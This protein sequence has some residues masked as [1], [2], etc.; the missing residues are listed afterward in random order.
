MS[1]SQRL[2]FPDSELRGRTARG[3]LLNAFFLGG[4]ESLVLIQG[5]VVIALL[6]PRTIG[7]Y[8]I[9]STTAVTIIQLRRVGIDEAFVQQQAPDQAAEFQRAFTIELAIAAVGSVVIAA[10]API[11]AAIYHD[12]RLLWLTLAVSYLPIGFALQAPQWIF[13]RSMDFLR[14]RVLQILIPVLTFVVTVPLVI[15]GFGVW[16]LVIGPA[17]G[18]LAAVV[19]G[20]AISPYRLGLRPDRAAWRYYLRF[21]WPVFV[22][23]ATLLALQQG[24]ITAFGLR[25][26]LAAAGYITLAATL[27]RYV[28][29]ADLILTTTIYPAICAVRDRLD[30]LAE[31]FVK[32]SRLTL[33]WAF[34]FGASF[35]LFSADLVSRVLGHRWA[36]AIPL[37]GGMA[38]ALALQQVGYNWFSFYRARGNSA[39]QAVESAVL[40]IAF[41]A[42][43]IPGL[44]VW[45][46]WGFIG[47]RV[48]AAVAVLAVRRHYVRRLLP[49][50][51]LLRVALPAATLV[52]AAAVPVLALRLALWG[53]PRTWGQIAVELALWGGGLVLWGWQLERSLVRELS[54]YL[55]ARQGSSR[56]RQPPGPTGTLLS[57]DRT[58]AAERRPDARD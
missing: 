35:M 23:A 22:T 43:A 40:L 37:L 1:S 38:A 14:L 57:D 42:L 27:T 16:S 32:S 56:S 26:G 51:S 9:V 17:V 55:R 12:Q 7:L 31:L 10:A 6:G 46:T 3:G 11:L 4:A 33:M 20:L 25:G 44:L 54:G 45:G 24:Q 48:L 36:P 15:S 5:L 28:D 13:F 2:A 34:P 47:G 18:N 21:S 50:V 41:L 52:L 49:R 8:G 30:T 58:H 39:P 53:S 29:R 19:A